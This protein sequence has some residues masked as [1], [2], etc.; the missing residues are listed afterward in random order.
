MMRLRMRRGVSITEMLTASFAFLLL[1]MGLV[2]LSN[3]TMRSWSFGTSKMT[4]DSAV[5]LAMQ[6][7]QK[8]LRDGRTASVDADGKLTVVYPYVNAQGD[9]D[10]Y[11]AGASTS[12]YFDASTGFLYQQPAGGAATVIGSRLTAV[13]FSVSGPQI[14]ISL[15]AFQQNGRFGGSTTLNSS[16]YLHNEPPQ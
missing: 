16:V 10:R 1:L 13:T 11:T 12:Y 8:A 3:S 14:D 4:A 7:L 15:T 5:T 9:Y 2:M 6:K